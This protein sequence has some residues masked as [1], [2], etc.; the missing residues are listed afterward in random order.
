MHVCEYHKTFQPV[1]S[2]E[3]HYIIYKSFYFI[4]IFIRFISLHTLT[5]FARNNLKIFHPSTVTHPASYTMG[6]LGDEAA[7][8]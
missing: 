1:Q 3:V 5:Q 4:L 7:G 6:I 8:A 2:S